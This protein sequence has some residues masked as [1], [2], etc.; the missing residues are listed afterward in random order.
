M[1]G[2][3]LEWDVVSGRWREASITPLRM[4]GIVMH[5]QTLEQITSV[6]VTVE[7]K[8][9]AGR[10]LHRLTCHMTNISCYKKEPRIGCI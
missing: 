2:R 9:V 6:L 4:K 3:C 10:H 5:L 7:E 1:M 8:R